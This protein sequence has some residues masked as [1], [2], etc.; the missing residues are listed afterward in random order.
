MLEKNLVLPFPHTIILP[1]YIIISPS[2]DID[3]NI[4]PVLKTD[5]SQPTVKLACLEKS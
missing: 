4:G 3:I 2:S 1:C 5:Q